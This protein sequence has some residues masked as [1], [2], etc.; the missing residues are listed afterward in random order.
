MALQGLLIRLPVDGVNG[1]RALDLDISGRTEGFLLHS[2]LEAEDAGESSPGVLADG[3]GDQ[4]AGRGLLAVDVPSVSE[5]VMSPGDQQCSETNLPVK[6]GC[7]H[8]TGG[9]A[10]G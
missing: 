4:H 7:R 10:V 8:R 6:S 5:S 2:Q 9:A 3:E 1:G